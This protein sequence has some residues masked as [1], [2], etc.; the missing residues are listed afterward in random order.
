MGLFRTNYGD[1]HEFW[2]GVGVVLGILA[3][4]VAF[5]CSLAFG[6]NAVGKHFTK[7]NCVAF[8]Q[9]TGRETRYAEY[10]YWSYDCLVKTSDDKWLPRDQ[11]REVVD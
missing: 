10:T 5:F 6:S 2:V 4:A 11:I 7:V 8:Q 9:Q 3:A 1:V